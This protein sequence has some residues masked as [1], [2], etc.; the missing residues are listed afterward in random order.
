[1]KALEGIEHELIVIDNA[2]QDGSPE[3][4]EGRFPFVK[5]TWNAENK[6][7]AKAN[8]QALQEA[9]GRY[10][11][12]LNP[13]T[14]V[15]E[16]TFTVCMNFME[17]HTDAGAVGVTMVDGGGNFLKESKRAYPSLWTSFFK[18]AGLSSMFPRSSLF[19]RY[20]L[21]HLDHRKN[22]EVDVL[23]GAFFM[24]KKVILEKTGG[25]DE[26]FFMYGED[27]DLSYRIQEMGFKNYY[28]AETTII[29]FKGESTRKGTLNYVRLFYK[30]MMIFVAKH[31][32]SVTAGIFRLFIG[33]AIW[34]RGG[35]S[36]IA[37]FI[38]KNGL[39]IVDAALILLSFAG[40][41]FTWNHYVKPEIIYDKRLLTIAL[42][43]F[44]L[45][46]LTASYYAGLYDKK[47]KR[48]R[49]IR[50]TL[51]AMITLL[52][53]Y[54]LLP[55]S[56]RFSRA[57]L[58]LGSLYS[59]IL[60]S[61][62]R[63]ILRKWNWIETEEEEKMGTII[64][65]TEEEFERAIRLMQLADKEER[66]LGRVSIDKD[67]G[68]SLTNIDHLQLFFR[69]IPVREIIFCQGKLSF[70]RIIHFC[71]NL[72]RGIRMRITAEQSG[73]IVGSDSSTRS[74]E[75]VSGE[76]KYEISIPANIRF[77]RLIDV[78][79]SI[80]MLAGFP[81]HLFFVKSPLRLVSNAIDVL[82]GKK[83][84]IGYC[85]KK[86]TDARVT[87]IPYLPKIK[88]GVI[89]PNGLPARET[90]ETEEALNMLDQLY[91]HDYTPFQDI[92]L[93]TKGYRWLGTV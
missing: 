61:I 55:E 25:F 8:N 58:L 40:A 27:I 77:K 29:H 45:I 26:T 89:G 18:M 23:A 11:V 78:L 68:H 36:A 63:G 15:G 3:Y 31:Y 19:A 14:I 56:L 24:S 71:K 85:S 13:D 48:G 32:H 34:V 35:V 39:P 74:G 41:K 86:D 88:T 46:F 22:H 42:P 92:F 10:I 80:L 12:F 62:D 44:T 33:M 6:G 84:W 91:A 83:S 70:N 59:F 2:S 64:A 9:S 81:I 73:S 69:D 30:A 5:F 38:R 87:E 67:D 57:I 76:S 60:M 90:D 53:I 72:P 37:G 75:F 52:A 1:M 79:T 47:Q 50:S 43:A 65:G 20:H 66:V 28:C 54:S 51:I 82:M 93:I 4:L 7:F 49:L 21:G 17:L 16:E